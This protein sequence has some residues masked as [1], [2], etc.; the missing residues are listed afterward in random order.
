MVTGITERN[1]MKTELVKLGYALRYIDEWQPKATLYRHRPAYNDEGKVT[2][3]IGTAVPNVPGNPDYVL[4]KA[5]IGLFPWMPGEKCECQ[6]CVVA[7]SEQIE[8]PAL[9]VGTS[10]PE[11]VR[12]VGT[13]DGRSRPA[14]IQCDVCGHVAEGA[15]LSGAQS[16]LRG[17]AKSH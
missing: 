11:P 13:Q 14:Q 15:S 3:A 8:E 16:K 17:H 1:Q 9:S 4:R 5:R 2:D 12:A 7:G 10:T 6:W